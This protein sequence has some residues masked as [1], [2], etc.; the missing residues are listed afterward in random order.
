MTAFGIV[1]FHER[2]EAIR[3][4]INE[5][6][7]SLSG[8]SHEWLYNGSSYYSTMGIDEF[9]FI[10]K[11]ILAHPERKDFYVMDYGAGNFSWGYGV[12][13][14]FKKQS[15]LPKDIRIHVISLIG[16]HSRDPEIVQDG[17]CTL[18]NLG[19]FKLEEIEDILKERMPP[20]FGDL[21]GQLDLII[22]AWTLRHLID[23][24]GS[25]AQLYNLL[26]PSSGVMFIDEFWFDQNAFPVGEIPNSGP[27][28]IMPYL[29]IDLNVKFLFN[30]MTNCKN[31]S[32][33]IART[34]EKKCQIPLSY[35]TIRHLPNPNLFQ[36]RTTGISVFQ[37]SMPNFEYTETLF[38]Q[39]Y[40]LLG[41]RSLYEELKPGSYFK[42]KEVSIIPK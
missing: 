16:E 23:P 18:Y 19:R 22:S 20:Q 26:R 35:S 38:F 41:S 36:R 40:L 11:T 17:N 29:V 37:G 3:K 28:S 13:N 9:S 33:A 10:K 34:N 14:F 30:P 27:L 25:F 15:D 6:F 31:P 12:A 24:L 39:D 7:D 32:Y 42:H 5:A 2:P 8:Y 21:T 1:D 4:C